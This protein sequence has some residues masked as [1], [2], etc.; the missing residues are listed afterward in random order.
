MNK[1]IHKNAYTSTGKK[2][3]EQIWFFENNLISVC[4]CVGLYLMKAKIKA[5]LNTQHY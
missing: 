5:I 1:I 2:L 3:S 4:M